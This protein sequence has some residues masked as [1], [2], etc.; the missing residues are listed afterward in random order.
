MGEDIEV[1]S[2]DMSARLISTSAF[3]T[4]AENNWSNFGGKESLQASTANAIASYAATIIIT[5]SLIDGMNKND[6]ALAAANISIQTLY[7]QSSFI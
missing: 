1:I 5:N 6:Y 2:A 3:N 4:Y 7:G